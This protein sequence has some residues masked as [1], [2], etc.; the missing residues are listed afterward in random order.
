VFFDQMKG[1][2]SQINLGKNIKTGGKNLRFLRLTLRRGAST[3]FSSWE[4]TISQ[5]ALQ[6]R[7]KQQ[8]AP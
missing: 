3:T 5:T 6:A 2:I 4:Q 8:S 7:Q 1:F